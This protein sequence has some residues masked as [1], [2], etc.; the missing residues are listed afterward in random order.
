[1]ENASLLHHPT[2]VEGLL[3]RLPDGLPGVEDL[4]AGLPD[5]PLQ[6]PFHQGWQWMLDNYTKFQIATW[7]SLIVHELVYFLACLP[8]FLFQ[9][10][11]F[12]RRFKIQNDR[13]E[14][15]EKQWK[16]LKLILFNHFCIQLPLIAGTYVF[17]EMFGIPYDWESM[18]RW[19]VLAAQVFGCAVIE[20]T[21]HYFLH[22]ALHDKRIYKH[23]HKVHHH[24]QSPFGLTAE[25][26]HPAE[27]LILGAGFFIGILSL[28][29]HVVMLWAWVT[30][31]LLETIDVHSGYDIP[32]LNP[33]HLIPFYAGAKVHDFHHYNFTGN[34]S[35]TFTWWDKLF[36]TDKQYKE[37]Q[38]K[39]AAK[40]DKLKSQ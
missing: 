13:P 10:I 37:Y 18:P 1:M 23:I 22:R 34:Y 33:F 24:Y 15:V 38:A 29:T 32:Y 36:G 26:A 9:F 7:G 17:T 40:Q 2:G 16:C 20:D 28:C 31:R 6:Q 27:T 4:L 5:N 30:I 21:W 35:S 12:M 3:A 25:Y 19:Y 8:A 11:P 14:T 39:M